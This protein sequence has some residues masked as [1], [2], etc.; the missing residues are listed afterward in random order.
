MINPKVTRVI[1]RDELEAHM[2][3]A[4]MGVISFKVE[5]QSYSNPLIQKLQE[6]NKDI[7]PME[8]NIELN[9]QNIYLNYAS[10]ANNKR[11]QIKLG[12]LDIVPCL[13]RVE[14]RTNIK[15]QIKSGPPPKPK[16]ILRSPGAIKDHIKLNN[17][18]QYAIDELT[19]ALAPGITEFA[20]RYSERPWEHTY[21]ASNDDDAYIT[22]SISNGCDIQIDPEKARSK[23]Y[24][25]LDFIKKHACKTIFDFNKLKVISGKVILN[26]LSGNILVKLDLFNRDEQ[27]K[28]VANFNIGSIRQN[29][30]KPGELILN[31]NEVTA[32][33][34]KGHNRYEVNPNAPAEFEE[35]KHVERAI[36][37]SIPSL[38]RRERD[39]RDSG[40]LAAL[41]DGRELPKEPQKTKVKSVAPPT[42]N[43]PLTAAGAGTFIVLL[44]LAALSGNGKAKDTKPL[45]IKDK[46]KVLNLNLESK[47]KPEKRPEKEE[48]KAK[49]IEPKVQKPA[50]K[51]PQSKPSDKASDNK[52]IEKKPKSPANTKKTEPKL[53]GDKV[54]AKTLNPQK[55]KPKDKD[56]FEL[57]EINVSIIKRLKQKQEQFKKQRIKELERRFLSLWNEQ[58][59]LS[60]KKDARS[61]ARLELVT[62]RL[63][64]VDESRF[65]WKKRKPS[66][67]ITETPTG[68]IRVGIPSIMMDQIMKRVEEKHGKR[69]HGQI[70]T[71]REMGLK[72]LAGIK[73]SKLGGLKTP[74]II[75]RI[76]AA[77]QKNN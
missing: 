69:A 14:E 34:P 40:R 73:I 18:Y 56:V 26:N 8:C 48:P 24:P 29:E 66:L 57:S 77:L 30:L 70:T 19:A 72:R 59:A 46:D 11:M 47:V 45:A 23:I 16:L 65:F 54:Q 67:L 41:L 68:T 71:V 60:K 50:P 36:K 39:A 27:K 12:E 32:L 64:L 7:S 55:L 53:S 5:L 43:V 63:A 6:R 25:V 20:N 49:V 38:G 58:R 15:K 3:R 44:M 52:K 42:N 2:I 28:L 76:R 1:T 4:Q 9:Q 13:K 17:N 22:Q 31:I 75:R 61:E 62:E 74:T 51:K 35:A 33:R 21:S 10:K 37:E